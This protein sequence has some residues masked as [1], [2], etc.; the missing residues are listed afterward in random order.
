VLIGLAR[1]VYWAFTVEVW[2]PVDEAQHYAYV[3]SLAR[4]QG[5]P[6]VGKDKLNLDILE[7][8]KASPTQPYQSQEYLLSEGADWGPFGESYEGGGVQGPIYYALLTPAYWISHPFGEVTSIFAVRIGSV[9]ISLLAVPLLWVLARR[10]FP[11]RPEIWLAAPALLILIQGFNSNVASVNNDSL[12]VPVCIAAMIPVAGAFHG[13]QMR[14]AVAG[15]VLLG[16][17]FLTKPTTTTL[18]LYTGLVLLWLLASRREP[19][20]AVLRWGIVYGAVAMAVVLPYIA[21]N[22]YE[23]GSYSASS[24]VHAITGPVQERLPRTFDSLKVHAH[25]AR[26]GFWDLQP[27]SLGTQSDYVRLLQWGAAGSVLIGLAASLRRRCSTEVALLIWL[28]AAVPLAFLT[29]LSTNQILFDAT[30]TV[31]GRHLYA[32]L[33]LAV[34]AFASGLILALGR[35]LGLAA[36]IAVLGLALISERELTNH[37]IDGTYTLGVL[38]GGLAPV[39]DQPVNEGFVDLDRVEL[40]APCPAEAVAMTFRDDPPPALTLLT[41]GTNGEL[42]PY[43]GRIGVIDIYTMPRPIAGSI[44]VDA[45]EEIAYSP[46]RDNP[47]ISAP[48]LSGD[49]VARIYCHV[50]NPRELRFDQLYPPLHPNVSYATLRA[51]PTLWYWAGWLT[52]ASALV[53]AASVVWPHLRGSWHKHRT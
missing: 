3:E 31:V 2:N 43:L 37:Y 45:G 11:T 25:N 51:W 38:E 6:V 48:G 14:Q 35:R 22:F 32:G 24:E 39:V 19:L 49:P 18:A 5:M 13:L 15:G 28:G 27:L 46:N 34:L 4:G 47:H 10:L 53:L 21:W 30:G 23:Y 50:S 20:S 7:V 16:L 1:G 52:L 17:A 33:G 44:A 26:V 12:V 42:A 8:A 41:Q 40:S 9:M 29:I 36:L